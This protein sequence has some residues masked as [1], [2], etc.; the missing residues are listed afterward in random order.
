MSDHG[1]YSDFLL[2]RYASFLFGRR[3]VCFGIVRSAEAILHP[4]PDF[5]AHSKGNSQRA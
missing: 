2:L 5:A 3:M 1:P 4:L